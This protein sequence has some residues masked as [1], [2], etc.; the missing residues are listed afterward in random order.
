MAA[1][2]VT[3]FEVMTGI[4]IVHILRTPNGKAL[5]NFEICSLKQNSRQAEAPATTQWALSPIRPVTCEGS[6][7]L[8]PFTA[9]P[10]I[11]CALFT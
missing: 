3:Y 5:N 1:K 11:N 7:V 4:H 6:N 8:G 2:M 10:A 9:G